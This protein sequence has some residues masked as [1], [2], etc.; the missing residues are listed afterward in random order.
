MR[1]GRRLRALTP[2]LLALPLLVWAQ[3][4]RPQPAQ[5][6]SVVLEGRELAVLV[7]ITPGGPLFNLKPLVESLGGQLSA[8]D[9]GES[10]SLKIEGT[11]VVVGSGSAVITVG[12]SI[13]SLSQPV[14]H[15]PGGFQVPLDFLRK[16]YGDLA[17]YSFEW[18]PE[19][20]RLVISRRESR[21]IK[22]V[23]LQGMTTVVLQ[24][25]ETPRYRL[26]RQPG[27]IEVQML[28]DRLAP[29]AAR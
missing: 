28:A 20:S 19:E 16:T 7:T 26:N 10:V 3:V 24:F 9:S 2:V 27:L 6:S 5:R 12:E 29:P 23:H 14:T 13:V 4:G 15:G 18:R 11:E 17:G 21:E 22:V 25:P 1:E 8:D